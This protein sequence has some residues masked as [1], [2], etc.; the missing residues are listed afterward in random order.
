MYVYCGEFLLMQRL[1]YLPTLG[2]ALVV[3]TPSSRT[4]VRCCTVIRTALCPAWRCLSVR[5]H[6]A[7]I[8]VKTARLRVIHPVQRVYVYMPDTAMVPNFRCSKDTGRK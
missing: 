6:I 4:V 1:G 8:A 2:V 3:T 5:L 7:T